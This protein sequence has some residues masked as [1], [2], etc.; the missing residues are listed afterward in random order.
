[1]LPKNIR[2]YTGEVIFDDEGK[3]MTYRVTV[4][5][6]STQP[7]REYN[8]ACKERIP[9]HLEVEVEEGDWSV[10]ISNSN[11]TGANS[12]LSKPTNNKYKLTYLSGRAS[13]T[14]IYLYFHSE[15][16]GDF[17]YLVNITVG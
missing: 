2:L 4:D 3:Y 12:F 6:R 16:K 10:V 1:V 17:S 15:R 7:V 8:F 5:T 9:A 11:M 13:E 14:K